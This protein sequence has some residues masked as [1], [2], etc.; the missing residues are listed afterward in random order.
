MKM[1]V[2]VCAMVGL[3]CGFP[4]MADSWQENALFNPSGNQLLAERSGRVT[5]YHNLTDAEVQRAMNQHF[6][7]IQA[8]MFTG[9]I[10]TNDSGKP[11]LDEATGEPLVEDDGCDD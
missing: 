8:M 10:V 9:T 5:I 1:V 11:L 2:G 3:S 6:P 7:R 4:V